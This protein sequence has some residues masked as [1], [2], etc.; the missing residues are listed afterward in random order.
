MRNL[1][2]VFILSFIVTGVA[3]AQGAN[4]IDTSLP[5]GN[6]RWLSARAAGNQTENKLLRSDGSNNTQLNAPTGKEVQIT[7]AKTPVAKGSSTG[8]TYTTAGAMNKFPVISVITPS[9][10][11]PTPNATDA[12]SNRLNMIATAAPT[13]VFVEIP[14][15]TINAGA[16]G[17]N[18]WNTGASP[19]Q[20]V[21]QSGDNVN[22]LAAG[23][24][25]ACTTGKWCTCR[26]VNNTT[27]VCT[28]S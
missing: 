15:A 28:A 3:M 11:Y 19:V 16:D 21:P 27:H 20:M 17:F 25:F 23:T 26:P 14:R 22:V 6:Q 12:I 10:S 8:W 1:I 5:L 18:L 7:V 4:D 2:R 24:P 13:A 9:T